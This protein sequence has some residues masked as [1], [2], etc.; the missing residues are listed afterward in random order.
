MKKWWPALLFL[1]LFSCS[2]KEPSSGYLFG[3]LVGGDG[4]PMQRADIQ[5]L[6]NEPTTTAPVFKTFTVDKKGKYLIPLTT[7]GFY[8]LRYC[9]VDHQSVEIPVYI[10][11]VKDVRLDVRLR[12]IDARPMSGAVRIIGDFNDFSWQQ[13]AVIM[14]EKG[15]VYHGQVTP[16]GDTLAYQIVG[17]DAA[18]HSINGSQAD[19]F[20]VDE[21]GDYISVLRVQKRVPATIKYDAKPKAKT[22]QKIVFQER[23]SVQEAFITITADIERRK[24]NM[25]RAISDYLTRGGDPDKL[26]VN[27]SKDLA[28]LDR[29]WK[30][31]KNDDIKTIRYWVKTNLADPDSATAAQVLQQIPPFS[32]FWS[33]HPTFLNTLSLKYKNERAILAYLQQLI[34]Q[35][36]DV[37]IKPFFLEG[38]LSI[39]QSIGD[40]E[41][42]AELYAYFENNFSSS[43]KAKSIR[44]QFSPQRKIQVGR[45]VPAFELVSM[46]RATDRVSNKSLLGKKFLLDFWATW[47]APC[48]DEMKFLHEAQ[49]RFG[50][51]GLV[52]I[53]VSLD[54]TP[55]DVTKFREGK[56]K[57]PWFNAY[58]KF[59]QDSRLVRDFELA[60]IPK[61]ILV[62]ESG[63]I[64]A[65]GKEI[66]GEALLKTLAQYFK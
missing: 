54:R 17:V 64:L 42:L 12:S 41:K 31:E 1:A 61:P 35:H 26:D 18:G 47:C 58:E 28:D 34:F 38:A 60:L 56:W 44:S 50:S 30:Q 25:N 27:W 66:R 11:R 46:E 2:N 57:M 49:A 29:L 4:Q 6:S 51:K 55:D 52:L 45:P 3:S 19:W 10:E 53:S 8:K 65:A 43:A 9:G 22:E 59:S 37:T 63:I 20:R 7:S 36:A 48:V 32:P 40:R 23:N 39:A 33:V 15:G 21:G 13:N 62:D 24:Q 5:W 14:Q 16:V